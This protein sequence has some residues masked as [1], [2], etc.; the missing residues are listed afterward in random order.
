VKLYSISN[1]FSTA[2]YHSFKFAVNGIKSHQPQAEINGI[3]SFLNL[4]LLNLLGVAA[5]GIAA[6]RSGR[7]EQNRTWQ[8]RL[9]EEANYVVNGNTHPSTRSRIEKLFAFDK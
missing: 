4:L 6:H 9:V 2:I 8:E 1:I 3:F 5:F 7:Y